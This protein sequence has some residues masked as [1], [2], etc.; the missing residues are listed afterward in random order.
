[1]R[2]SPDREYKG[3]TDL[4][5]LAPVDG[6]GEDEDRVVGGTL[7]EFWERELDASRALVALGS[8]QEASEL[9]LTVI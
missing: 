8:T 6:D 5:I 9:F 3:K 1:M 2:N 4:G 7:D